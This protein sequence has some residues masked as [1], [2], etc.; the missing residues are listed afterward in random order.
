M[1]RRDILFEGRAECD[2]EGTW[3]S[4]WVVPDFDTTGVFEVQ[5]AAAY[6]GV[7]AETPGARGLY[8]HEGVSDENGDLLAVVRSHHLDPE[9]SL[10]SGAVFHSFVPSTSRFSLQAHDLSV[11][12]F[13]ISV[14]AI[15]RATTDGLD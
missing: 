3:L 1:A 14:R 5:V 11:E 12:F 13:F 4:H 9:Q 10:G 6:M 8:I 15:S 7:N 2:S